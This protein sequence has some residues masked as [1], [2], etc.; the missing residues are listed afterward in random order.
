M[1]AA[2]RHVRTQERGQK[3]RIPLDRVGF[4][5]L[6]QALCEENKGLVELATEGE[7]EA[8]INALTDKVRALVPEASKLDAPT[9]RQLLIEWGPAFLQTDEALYG[10]VR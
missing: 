4:E 10:F 1:M 2:M 3:I 7:E 9:M 5:C 6:R 8:W